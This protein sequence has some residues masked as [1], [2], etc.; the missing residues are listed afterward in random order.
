MQP[1]DQPATDKLEF[2]PRASLT[3]MERLRIIADVSADA[4]YD[5]D[6]KMGA[7]KKCAEK[8][9]GGIKTYSEPEQ[10]PRVLV[11]VPFP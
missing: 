7:M 2:K 11:R 8:L 6:I 3:D 5:W 10:G 9:G 4:I 1:K